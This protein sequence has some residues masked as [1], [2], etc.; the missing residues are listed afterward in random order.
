MIEARGTTTDGGDDEGAALASEDPS[1]Q[2]ALDDPRGWESEE[3]VTEPMSVEELLGR[4]DSASARIASF[5]LSA[6]QSEPSTRALT[7]PVQ[8]GL[9]AGAREE[10][11]RWASF[12]R[13][14]EQTTLTR[15]ASAALIIGLVVVSLFNARRRAPESPS[16]PRPAATSS[17]RQLGSEAVVNRNGA[18]EIEG[19]I[20]AAG[21]EPA[22]SSGPKG[23]PTLQR[24]AADAVLAGDSKRALATYRRLSNG[25]PQ[26]SVYQEAV[27]ILEARLEKAGESP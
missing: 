21:A 12:R 10:R 5:S 24:E 26:A 18:S 25:D 15:K 8:G 7:A 4:R 9:E 16:S 3:P 27:R 11:G 2:E 6:E 20:A 22:S 14:F 17:A 19:S 1:Q 13:N 23:G